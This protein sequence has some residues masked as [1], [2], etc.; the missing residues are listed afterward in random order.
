MGREVRK[1]FKSHGWFKGTVDAFDAKDPVRPFHVTF[2]V[3]RGGGARGCRHQA[4]PAVLKAPGFNWLKVNHFQALGFNM[5]TCA[6]P[7]IEDEDHE[8]LSEADV[9]RILIP[10][11]NKVRRRCKLDPSLKARQPPVSNFDCEKD[12]TVLSTRTPLFLSLHPPLR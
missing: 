1:F 11:P 12:T 2:E 10:L 5:S 4:D 7:Y 3:R 6:P 8:D 9:K